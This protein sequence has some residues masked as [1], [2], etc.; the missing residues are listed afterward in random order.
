MYKRDERL[1]DFHRIIQDRNAAKFQSVISA[2]LFARLP[3]LLDWLETQIPAEIP[4]KNQPELSL[5]A[6]GGLLD[7]GDAYYETLFNVHG[8]L[9]EKDEEDEKHTDGALTYAARRIS[10]LFTGHRDINGGVPSA[11]AELQEAIE[12]LLGEKLAFS[13]QF[14]T[15][16]SWQLLTGLFWTSHTFFWGLA[17]AV[18][19]EQ[20]RAQQV[21]L[22]PDIDHNNVVAH[23]AQGDRRMDD[24]AYH[25]EYLKKQAALQGATPYHYVDQITQ[26]SDTTSLGEDQEFKLA[27]TGR[28]GPDAVLQW[29]DQLYWPL[30]Q[31]AALNSFDDL[32]ELEELITLLCQKR[33]T[34]LTPFPHLLIF[35]LDRYLQLTKN[36]SFNLKSLAA[37]HYYYDA[38]VAGAI[39]AEGRIKLAAWKEN[40]MKDS[41]E[42]VYRALSDQIPDPDAQTQQALFGWVAAQDKEMWLQHNSSELMLPILEQLQQG[43]LE[44]YR[45]GRWAK[46]ALFAAVSAEALNWKNYKVLYALWETDPTEALRETLAAQ[47]TAFLLKAKFSWNSGYHFE[48]HYLQQALHF[49]RL[50]I[51]GPDAAAIHAEL[52]KTNRPWHEGWAYRGLSGY[53]QINRYIFLLTCGCC[54]A[55]MHYEQGDIVMART[56][57]QPLDAEIVQQYRS[58]V[59][60][61]DRQHY[62]LPMRLLIHTLLRFEPAAIPDQLRQKCLQLDCTEDL[63]ILAETLMDSA[64]QLGVPVATALRQEVWQAVETGFPVIAARLQHAKHPEHLQPYRALYD[65]CRPWFT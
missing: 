19:L 25:R 10:H 61:H 3:E 55:Y 21:E 18:P 42:R 22:L 8:L 56:A 31:A 1:I 6:I 32:A 63:L 50:C 28:L 23:L 11:Y 33:S 35:L 16:K 62:L 57:W 2:H 20:I 43:Y 40:G 46:A 44:I 36:I 51:S 29:L 7:E 53:E 37:K 24:P 14:A 41:I 15:F 17:D 38:A 47:M 48:E 59:S 39:E 52:T 65:K 49:T 45:S 34:L 9:P 5:T 12:R 30:A 26:G 60:D 4:G 13:L 27:L 64:S 58:T 54:R